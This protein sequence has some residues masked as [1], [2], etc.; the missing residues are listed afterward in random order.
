MNS[1]EYFD[2]APLLKR[3]REYL[4][5]TLPC[6]NERGRIFHHASDVERNSP[7]TFIIARVSKG[8]LG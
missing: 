7:G 2:N 1:A 4:S 3:A 5:S 8:R 6:L